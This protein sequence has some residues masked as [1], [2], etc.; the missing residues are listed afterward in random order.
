M[1]ARLP[2]TRSRPRPNTLRASL[3]DNLRE[4][5]KNVADAG[6][7]ATARIG[8]Q[9]AKFVAT[10]SDRLSAIELTIDTHGADLDVRL[11][12]RA[13]ATADLLARRIDKFEIRRRTRP[14]KS[15]ASST[16]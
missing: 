7:G 9:A 15:S 1:A 6:G 11:G 14:T 12:K 13:D 10:I 2:P 16:A 4:F 8:A 3:A 5:E